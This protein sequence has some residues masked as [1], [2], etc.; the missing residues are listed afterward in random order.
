MNADNCKI[1]RNTTLGRPSGL[2]IDFETD[3]ICWGDSL[4][5]HIQCSD[6]DGTKDSVR[7]ID[8][9][10][11]PVPSSMTIMGGKSFGL[12]SYEVSSIHTVRTKETVNLERFSKYVPTVYRT[13]LKILSMYNS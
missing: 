13:V 1:L 10:P 9:S 7:K 6:L 11:S 12:F 2:T 8:I 5:Q 3:E 4:L